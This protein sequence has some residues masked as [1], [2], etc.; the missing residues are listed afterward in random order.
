VRGGEDELVD[1]PK[2]VPLNAVRPPWN[3]PSQLRHRDL[4]ASADSVIMCGRHPGDCHSIEG[5]HKP[6]Q[7]A[8][9]IELLP[10][11]LGMEYQRY[12]L[13]WVSSS[14]GQRFAGL[15]IEFTEEIREVGPIPY[16]TGY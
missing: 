8:E 6:K 10:E 4:H 15:M 2:L 13:E 3:G 7:R 14:E 12:G 11:D 16:S 5:N 1:I 9:A